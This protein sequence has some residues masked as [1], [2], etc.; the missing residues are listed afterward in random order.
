VVGALAKKDS[1]LFRSLYSVTMQVQTKN[2]NSVKSEL[3]VRTALKE[4]VFILQRQE[5]LEELKQGNAPLYMCFRDQLTPEEKMQTVLSVDFIS[6]AKEVHDAS[7]GREL[8]QLLIE[9]WEAVTRQDI[10]GLLLADQ[11]LADLLWE[12]LAGTGQ[13]S[14]RMMVDI[15]QLLSQ[16]EMSFTEDAS[17]EEK[18]F[19]VL[20]PLVGE[21]MAE[22]SRVL[23]LLRKLPKTSNPKV[24][25]LRALLA[26]RLGEVDALVAL[27]KDRKLRPVILDI[28]SRGEELLDWESVRIDLR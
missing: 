24:I 9:Q 1:S 4:P 10:L 17:R 23:K 28:L 26:G 13:R 6:R 2:W 12:V 21:D 11:W 19:G 27:L 25:F 16:K 14:L 18:F 20:L 3:E 15:L 22:K 8:I 7:A 5:I